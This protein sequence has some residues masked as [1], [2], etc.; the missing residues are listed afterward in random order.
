MAAGGRGRVH[1]GE[2]PEG[3]VRPRRALVGNGSSQHLAGAFF[4]QIA[5]V[6]MQHVPYRISSQMVTDLVGGE[7]PVSFQL[8]LGSTP[9]ELSRFISAEIAKWRGII[10][11]G[12]IA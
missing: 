4:E 6:R 11:R 3:P 1:G 2:V 9:E 7:V 5:G 8:V 12:G 10:T